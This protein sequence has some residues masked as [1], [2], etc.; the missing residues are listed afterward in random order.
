MFL[1][2]SLFEPG[3]GWSGALCGLAA[4][5]TNSM[6]GKIGCGP[7]A[8]HQG[9]RKAKRPQLPWEGKRLTKDF[10][11]ATST[12]ATCSQLASSTSRF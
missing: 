4:S 11:A 6:N 1:L 3:G 5:P 2:G 10:L 8:S 7:Q 9:I 12:A